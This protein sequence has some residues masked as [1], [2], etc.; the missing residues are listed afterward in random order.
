M[1]LG[2]VVG[3]LGRVASALLV[4]DLCFLSLFFSFWHS[5]WE[6]RRG[7]K[8]TQVGVG[9]VFVWRVHA[10]LSML[11]KRGMPQARVA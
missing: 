6:G 11:C 9:N 5:S 1:N 10:N 2:V 4:L 8:G 7:K 3:I